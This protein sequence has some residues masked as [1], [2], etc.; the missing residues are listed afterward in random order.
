M[1]DKDRLIFW[2]DLFIEAS[3]KVRKTVLPLFG[4]SEG[5]RRVGVS[6]SGDVTKYIDKVA[7]DTVINFLLEKD[8]SFVLVSEELGV[9]SFGDSPE[10][11]VVV[12]PIDGS[13]NAARGIPVFSISLAFARKD[14][15]RDILVGVV[16]DVIIGDLFTAV[17]NRGAYF[18]GKQIKGS[19]KTSLVDSL[20][21]FDLSGIASSYIRKVGDAIVGVRRV[22]HLGSNA[23]EMCLVAKGAYD[24]F[25][26]LRGKLRV[27]DIAAA[28]LVIEEAGGIVIDENGN[29]LNA[30]LDPNS[31][32]AFIAAGNRIIAKKILKLIKK[33]SF[34]KIS[35]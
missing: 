32:V 31:R 2:R 19:N 9:R 34:T 14:S 29:A 24:A 17:K 10:G 8:V 12:D 30:R 16:Q 20:V 3:E 5:R 11:F 1:N 15:L 21:G 23:Y 27:T 26:D 18:N 33:N 22:R 13:E 28:T 7:E 25:V 4:T 6:A 35:H